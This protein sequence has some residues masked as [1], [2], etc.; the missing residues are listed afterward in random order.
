VPFIDLWK[1]FL[2]STQ[3]SCKPIFYQ[4]ITTEVFKEM[5]KK[6]FPIS[7][8]SPAFEKPSLSFEEVKCY[9]IFCWIYSKGIAKKLENSSHKLKEELILCLQELTEGDGVADQS[10]EWIKQRD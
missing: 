1:G 3:C 9:S 5:I 7:T 10:Q 4:F 2:K 8:S 6:R